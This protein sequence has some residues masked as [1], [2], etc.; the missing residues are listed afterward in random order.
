MLRKNSSPLEINKRI[1]DF[2]NIKLCIKHDDYYPLWGGGSKARKIIPIIQDAEEKGANALV[3]SGAPDS[4]HARVVALA[5]AELG[6]PCAVVVHGKED[7]TKSNLKIMKISGAK[8]YFVKHQNV[9][10]AMDFMME[11]FRAQGKSP[12]YVWGGGHSILGTLSFFK[13]VEEF[14]SQSPNWLP[15]FVLVPSGTG[16]TQAGLHVGFRE[17]S[18]KIQVIGISVARNKERGE[19]A[20]FNAAQALCDHMSLSPKMAEGIDFRDNWVGEGYSK[21]YPQL[22]STI[23]HAATKGLITDP[24]YTGKALT[25]LF[26]LVKN[27]EIPCT[28]KVLFWHTGGIMNLLS[29]SMEIFE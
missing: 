12:Y 19:K 1:S 22:L 26:D 5:A 20:V 3:T 28:A 17:I 14:H 4:N 7:Y 21:P 24:T 23:K 10:S 18:P 11:E 2:L 13:A 8:L 16:G 9:A 15:D 25:A 27:G 29:N 6:W